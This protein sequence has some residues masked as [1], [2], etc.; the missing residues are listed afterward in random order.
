MVSRYVRRSASVANLS[1]EERE[2]LMKLRRE[3]GTKPDGLQEL[4][5]NEKFELEARR[6]RIRD[7]GV[8]ME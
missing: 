6:K 7:V 4:D 8:Q 3:A 2:E 1:P 5:G